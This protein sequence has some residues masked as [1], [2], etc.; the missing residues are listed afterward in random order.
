MNAGDGRRP[1]AIGCMAENSVDGVRL[2]AGL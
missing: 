2:L 1:F